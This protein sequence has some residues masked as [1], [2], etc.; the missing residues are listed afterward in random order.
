LSDS[1][2][3]GDHFSRLSAGY[4]RFRPRYPEALFDV[5]AS[6]APTR[7]RAWD[8]GAGSGQAT[9]ALADRFDSVVATDISAEQVARAPRT[10]NVEWHVAA[11]EHA[12]MIASA[13]VDLVS[14]AQA[15]HWFDHPRFYAE[16]RRVAVPDG[17][18]AAWTYGPARM[19]GDAGRVIHR[20]MYGDVG[21]YWPPERRHVDNEYRDIPFPFARIPAPPLSLE[22]DWTVEQVA[23]YLRTMSATGRYVEQHGTDPVVPVEAELRGVWGG[24]PTRRVTWPLIVLAGRASR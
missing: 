16:V 19:E 4:A 20:Y 21:A 9:L 6:I 3:R 15:L 13:S 7:R 8:V 23:G 2:A 22:Y 5:L 10:G 14:V 17:V 11:A 12:P 1:P 24:L 18:I